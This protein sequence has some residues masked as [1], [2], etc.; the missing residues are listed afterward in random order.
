MSPAKRGSKCW[1]SFLKRHIAQR[2]ALGSPRSGVG[3]KP[4]PVAP[5]GQRRQVLSP[6]ETLREQQRKPPEVCGLG[7]QCG[8][9]LCPS[10]AS[11]VETPKPQLLWATHC[12]PKTARR[13]SGHA[14]GSPTYVFSHFYALKMLERKIGGSLA[15]NKFS[16]N[17]D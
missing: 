3:G 5:L 17:L 6:A 8:L 14:S 13:C 10:E 4:S 1:V 15:G 11:E 2:G 9:G 16:Y 7:S 12:L